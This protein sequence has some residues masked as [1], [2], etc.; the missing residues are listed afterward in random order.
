[1]STPSRHY[2]DFERP[3]AEIE[4]KLDELSKLSATAEPGA[5]DQEI[6]ALRNRAD[7]FRRDV[8]ARLD[9][10]QKTQVARHPDRPHFLDYLRELVAD[11]VE[12]KGDRAFGDDQAVVGGL[13]RFRGE[14]VVVMGHE[15]GRDTDSRLKHNFGMARPEG[16]RKA[17]RL[18]DLAEQ[19]NLPVLTFVDTAGAYPGV[20]AEE[21]GQGEAIARSTERGLTLGVPMIATIT[22]EG[23]SGGALALAGANKVLILE[24][25]IYSVISPEAGSSILFRDRAQAAHMARS[26]KITA[27]E[28]IGL[29]IVDRIIPEPA[30][31]AHADGTAA[32]QAVGEAVA[33]ELRQ[34]SALSPDALRAQRAER[35]YAIG[36][37]FG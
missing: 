32:M 12:L 16:Y 33:D 27:Q 36:R 18:M 23:G 8:Y 15:K 17:V 20:G 1:M 25:S 22:G 6:G 5:F 9:P 21:R 28:L 37:S 35:F 13:G 19:F 24:H 30:G 2:L 3:V 4:A 7:R 34:L 31:G 10:W 26:M 11:F 14:G 29:K